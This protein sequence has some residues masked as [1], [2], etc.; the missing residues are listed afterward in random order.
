[1]STSSIIRGGSGETTITAVQTGTATCHVR[2]EEGRDGASPM[3]RKIDIF[4]DTE[5]TAPKPIYA[6]V[7]E[8]PEGV[9][10]VDTGDNARNSLES[11]Y[12]PRWNP[13]F[14]K[15]VSIK[16]APEE[17]IGP[18]L[19]RLGVDPAQD[20]AAVL[21]THMHH[22][23]TGGLGHFPHTPIL[24]SEENLRVSRRRK[25]MVGALTSSWPRW[26]DPQPLQFSGGP[27]GEFARSAPVTSDGS[28]LAVEIPGHM[29]GQ[30]A[31]LVRAGDVTYA[32]VGDLTY[33]EELLRTDVVDGVTTDPA[34]SLLSQRKVKA[35]A[36][37]EPIV[38]LP[39]HDPG[40]VERL[41]AGRVMSV[42]EPSIALAA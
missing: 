40:V 26:L 36:A 6:F 23:H 33:S 16:V 30:V 21:M 5:W 8:H 11:G 28:I 7:V 24:V 4:R 12:L 35:L 14:Q 10:V 18:Q 32:L 22:D 1:M 3:R 25:T 29:A 15:M 19:R 31:Y 9:F 38:L 2:Q 34:V 37:S 42:S 17:E 39:A 13:F 41:P 20:V 27:V